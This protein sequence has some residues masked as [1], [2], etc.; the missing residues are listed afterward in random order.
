MAA[1]ATQSLSA[2]TIGNLRRQGYRLETTFGWDDHMVPLYVH[3]PGKIRPVGEVGFKMRVGNLK[4]IDAAEA[5]YLAQKG[6]SGFFMWKPEECFTHEFTPIEFKER[7]GGGV[8]AVKADRP[9]FG[10]KWCRAANPTKG[11]SGEA[12]VQPHISTA[13]PAAELADSA[14]PSITTDVTGESFTSVASNIDGL[15]CDDCGTVMNTVSKTGKARSLK[16]QQHAL[17][18]HKKQHA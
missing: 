12:E 1:T 10:C 5:Q 13:E 6:A 15:T 18:L 17:K 4:N 8:I 3:A 11:L 16:Q 2:K 9:V 7:P 14:P